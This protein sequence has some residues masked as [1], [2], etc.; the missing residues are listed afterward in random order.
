MPVP[1]RAQAT[2]T[3]EIPGLGSVIG[4]AIGA[5]VGALVVVG[6]LALAWTVITIWG[7]VRALTGRSRVMLIVS[8]SISI[9]VT[10]IGLVGNLANLGGPGGSGGGDVVV[11]LVFFAIAVATVVL[12]CLRPSARFFAAHRARRGR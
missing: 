3:S 10:G 1:V 5:A 4:G 2:W 11:S 9:L 6:L 7:S 8:G 12:L